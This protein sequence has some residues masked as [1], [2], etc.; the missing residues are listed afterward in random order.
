VSNWLSD[1]LSSVVYPSLGGLVTGT[2][3]GF[4]WAKRMNRAQAVS[5]ELKNAQEIILKWEALS[6]RYES[7]VQKLNDKLEKLEQKLQNYHLENKKLKAELA[8]LKK[9]R[10]NNL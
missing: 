5:L 4:L 2:A 1:F 7:E 9:H 8:S 6:N 3:G 10:E